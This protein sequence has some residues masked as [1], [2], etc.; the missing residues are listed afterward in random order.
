MIPSEITDKYFPKQ[1]VMKF[2]Y[3]ITDAKNSANTDECFQS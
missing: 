1:K 2:W 3:Q